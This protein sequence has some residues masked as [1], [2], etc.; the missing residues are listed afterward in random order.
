MKT[1]LMIAALAG[2]A[3]AACAQSSITFTVIMDQEVYAHGQIASG[4]VRVNWSAPNSSSSFVGVAYGSFKLQATGIASGGTFTAP[5]GPMAERPTDSILFDDPNQP[6]DTPWLVGRRPGVQGDDGSTGGFRT[7]QNGTGPTDV[8]YVVQDEGLRLTAMNGGGTEYGIE[9]AQYP[10]AIIGPLFVRDASGFDLFRFQFLTP[11]SGFFDLTISP[12]EIQG[13][14]YYAGGGPNIPF[15]TVISIGDR[16]VV[17]AASAGAVLC[18]GV[19]IGFRRR[20]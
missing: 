3:G 14:S 20:R 2:S 17:P 12:V 6:D 19:A 16:V 9:F 13:V 7:P 15:K 11:S 5:V 1:L 10:R 18:L 8:N 4:V